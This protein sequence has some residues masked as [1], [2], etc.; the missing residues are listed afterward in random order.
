MKNIYSNMGIYVA[1]DKKTSEELDSIEK[2]VKI[3]DSSFLM[4]N[5]FVNL[6]ANVINNVRKGYRD[7]N[8]ID[9]ARKT[10]REKARERFHEQFDIIIIHQG[11]ID[12]WLPGASHNEKKVEQ[13]IESL[14]CVF[15]Y[16]IITTGRGTPAN[17]PSSARVLPF[18][19][20]QTTLFRQYPEKMILTDAIMN[21]L[22]VKGT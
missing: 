15:R 14:R 8:N 5:G 11:I 2:G 13:F 3:E 9:V 21:M 19:T 18:S 4:T 22:P 20:I 17:I 7:A 6:S 1:N 10:A 16:V 12:K